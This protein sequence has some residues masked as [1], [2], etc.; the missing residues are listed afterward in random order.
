MKRNGAKPRLMK[1]GGPVEA[2]YN[3]SDKGKMYLNICVNFK[4][5]FEMEVNFLGNFWKFQE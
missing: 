1:Q 3:L 4:I 5:M 2:S